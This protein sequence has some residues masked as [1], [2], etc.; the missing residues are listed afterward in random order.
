MPRSGFSAR[1]LERTDPSPRFDIKHRAHVTN[2]LL[3]CVA[4]LEAAINELFQDVCDGHDSYTKTL[5]AQSQ[6]AMRVFWQFTED[7]NR[8]AFSILDKYQISLSLL[9]MPIF[10]TGQQPYQDVYLLCQLRNELVHYKPKSLGAEAHH[11][12]EEKLR[13]KFPTKGLMRAVG[14]PWFPDV[15]L[16]H[17]CAEWA[18]QASQCFADAFFHQIDVA[19][20]YQRVSF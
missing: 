17:G 8:S 11:K 20:N 13:G 14:N 18:V 2:A 19:P 15:C 1:E 16:G 10:S 6:S 4:F 5:D 3:T 7:R 9:R 12:L